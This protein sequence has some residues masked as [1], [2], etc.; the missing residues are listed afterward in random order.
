MLDRVLYG[1]KQTGCQWSAVVCQ[2]LVDEHGM[3]QCRADPCAY[4]KIV[5]GV[6]NLI[7]VVHVDDVL[8]SGEKRV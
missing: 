5:E 6:V 4:K 8:V 3:K 1:M 2:A 7:L